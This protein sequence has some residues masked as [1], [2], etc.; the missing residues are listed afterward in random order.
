MSAQ[1]GKGS[2]RKEREKEKERK[3]EAEESET[4]DLLERVFGSGCTR[5]AVISLHPGAGART[6]VETL[7][8]EFRK[9][10]IR[11]GVT[12]VPRI[13]LDG[14]V[15]QILGAPD[16]E[17]PN[18]I[19]ISPDD[20][21]LYLVEANGKEGG[22]RCLRAYDLGDDKIMQGLELS[23]PVLGVGFRF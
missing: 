3:R 8:V 7:A 18:G 2:Q 20:R 14:G 12:R 4:P 23:G 5:L 11:V 19:V 15:H 9:R 17:V 13:D 16:I 1:H 10:G 6:V 22:A 21:T